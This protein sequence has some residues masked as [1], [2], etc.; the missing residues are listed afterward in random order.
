MPFENI[1]NLQVRAFFFNSATDYLPYYKNFD[2]T[3]HSTATLLEVLD[4]V[5]SKNPDF[6]FPNKNIILKVN[7]LV[8]TA[9][10]LVS[11]VVQTL[12]KELQIDPA[13]SYRSNNGLILND[14]DFMQSFELLAPYASDEDKAYYQSLYALHYASE[15]S[16]YNR[17]YIGDA[18]LL[19]ASKM[20]KDGNE[21][22]EEILKT[23]SDEYNGIRCCEYENN[24]LN[25]EDHEE[26][27]TALKKMITLK[28]TASAYDKCSFGKKDHNIDVETLSFSNVALYSGSNKN[29]LEEVRT[30]IKKHAASYIAFNRSSKLA[31]QTLMDTHFEIAHQKA[32]TMLLDAVDSGA[33]VLVCI[34]RD[35]TIFQEALASCERVMGRDIR[36]KIIS[37]HTLKELCTATA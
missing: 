10:T 21:N 15:T 7:N 30:L 13:T 20:I 33:S 5:K 4:K 22:K 12:G 14:D 27:I 25:G 9:E 6:S 35:V 34:K 23:I 37:V 18:I 24:L 36:L 16:N 2:I 17:Q 3:L 32:G 19:L 31:G 1:I 29:D 26:T 8:T 28:D 11:D